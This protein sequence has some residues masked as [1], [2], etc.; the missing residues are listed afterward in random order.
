MN[1]EPDH[2][3]AQN[4]LLDL[5]VKVGRQTEAV[6][7]A[8]ALLQ[9]TPDDTHVIRAKIDTL[10]NL[11]DRLKVLAFADT[12][13]AVDEADQPLRPQGVRVEAVR[14][15]AI[16]LSMDGR[17]VEA[18]PFAE[19]Y[20]D[21]APHDFDGHVL[22]LNI[23]RALRYDTDEILTR[24]RTLLE[25]N[26][27]DINAQLLQAVAYRLA[28][29]RGNSRKWLITVANAQPTDEAVIRR[30]IGELDANE[31]YRETILV[32]EAAAA[33]IEAA[34][35]SRVL[36]HRLFQASRLEDA[37]EVLDHA[38][39]DPE[40]SDPESDLLG[41]Q[42]MILI[43]LKRNDETNPVVD[44]L[45]DRED[46]PVGRGVGFVPARSGFRR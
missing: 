25:A 29:D 45:A 23:L 12:L 21:W 13:L 33:N 26:P 35:V 27:D 42:A 4:E 17:F 15:K 9:K 32:L 18:L 5:Y 36:A 16:A 8:D 2:P 40:S 39:G 28:G 46:D 22:T 37:L 20:N 34:W 7:V 19:R 38:N 24:V 11:R 3:T 14:A 1:L 10:V 43:Q 44:L 6:D 41:L 31:L 30:L